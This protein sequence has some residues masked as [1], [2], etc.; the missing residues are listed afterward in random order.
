MKSTTFAFPFSEGSRL[1]EADRC[2]IP[3]SAQRFSAPYQDPMFGE[4][5]NPAITAVGVAKTKAQGQKT[6]NT[7]TPR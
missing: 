6:T 7:V 2:H 1:I 5:P 4:I 3:Q